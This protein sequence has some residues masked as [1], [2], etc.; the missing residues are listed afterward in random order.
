MTSYLAGRGANTYGESNNMWHLGVPFRADAKSADRLKRE[1][2]PFIVDKNPDRHKHINWKC[3]NVTY[4]VDMNENP[5]GGVRF[6]LKISEMALDMFWLVEFLQNKHRAASHFQNVEL[7]HLRRDINRNND[8]NELDRVQYILKELEEKQFKSKLIKKDRKNKKKRAILDIYEVFNNVMRD[9]IRAI[10]DVIESSKL[11]TINRY[12]S[13]RKDVIEKEVKRGLMVSNEIDVME[14]L[15][16]Q[17]NKE[18]VISTI[19]EQA[20]RME[21]VRKYANTELLKISKTYKQVV[22]Y[23]KKD[24]RCYSTIKYCGILKERAEN[25]GFDH[26]YDTPLVNGLYR[27]DAKHFNYNIPKAL[28]KKYIIPNS[29]KDLE[30]AYQIY[31]RSMLVRRRRY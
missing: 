10:Y 1:G 9:S 19:R 18:G 15:R 17:I 30:D 7:D 22:P 8:D 6:D 31:R 3:F 16:A 5:T 20:E 21:N 12:N 29:V 26:V 24:G 2:V 4:L 23:I 11:N 28:R 25:V 13:A 27:I 14:R